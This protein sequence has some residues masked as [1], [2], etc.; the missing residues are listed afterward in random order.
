MVSPLSVRMKPTMMP[1]IRRSS[2]VV[3]EVEAFVAHVSREIEPVIVASRFRARDRIPI[4]MDI[5]QADPGGEG[6]GTIQV[7]EERSK[8]PITQTVTLPLAIL[9]KHGVARIYEG[10]GKWVSTRDVT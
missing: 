9:E 3:E 8:P 5:R 4:R 6:S 1:P 10:D 7:E 2:P